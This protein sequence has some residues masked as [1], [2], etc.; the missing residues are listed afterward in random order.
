M[1]ALVPSG[2]VTFPLRA[3]AGSI[4]L[5]PRIAKGAPV[6]CAAY[7]LAANSEFAWTVGLRKRPYLVLIAGEVVVIVYVAMLTFSQAD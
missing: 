2:R 6:Y 4:S 3:S 1:F 7:C 5:A